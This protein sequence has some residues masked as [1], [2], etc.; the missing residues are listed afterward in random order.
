MS[1]EQVI[2]SFRESISGS[3]Y[4]FTNGRCLEFAWFLIRLFPEGIIYT[5]EDHCWAKI[6]GK[7]YDVTGEV[8]PST[9]LIGTPVPLSKSVYYVG[10]N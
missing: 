8:D 7:L 1:P 2:T 6:N 3:E 4:E 9:I 5:N 10:E